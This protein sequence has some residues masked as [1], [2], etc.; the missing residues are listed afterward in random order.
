VTV[1]EQQEWKIPP[2]I[3]N[4]KN[5]KVNKGFCQWYKISSRIVSTARPVLRERAP[6]QFYLQNMMGTNVYYKQLIVVL[7]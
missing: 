3:S 1:K 7:K 2:N 6:Y 5:A 4:W